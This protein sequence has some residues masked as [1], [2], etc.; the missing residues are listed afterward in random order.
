MLDEAPRRLKP[1]EYVSEP[2]IGSAESSAPNSVTLKLDPS[3]HR[4][5]KS[6]SSGLQHVGFVE[7]ADGQAFHR[8]LQV[9]ANF[10]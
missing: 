10:K 9:F 1:D 6:P 7:R 8:S 5:K 4:S 2:G 3:V